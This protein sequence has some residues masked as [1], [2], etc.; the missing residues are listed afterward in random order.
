MKKMTASRSN[1]GRVDVNI[2]LEIIVELN[3][4]TQK[5]S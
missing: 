5:N 2:I 3:L 1:D 4:F